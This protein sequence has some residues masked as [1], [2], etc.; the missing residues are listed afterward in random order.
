MFAAEG[1]GGVGLNDGFVVEGN[2]VVGVC[3]VI[4]GESV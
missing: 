4:V 3:V 1:K 2:A